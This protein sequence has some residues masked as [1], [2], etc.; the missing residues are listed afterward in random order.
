MTY[1]A[2]HA[3][4]PGAEPSRLSVQ[5]HAWLARLP[6]PVRV[7][8]VAAQAPDLVNRIAATWDDV[9][10]TASL[11]EALLVES[12]RSLPVG[13]AAELLRLYEYHTRCCASEAPS[14]TW[15]LPAF[16]LPTGGGALA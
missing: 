13:I 3:P 9:A 1:P 4:A 5:A 6:A 7:H 15:E 2:S 16:G 10:G 11:L 14:T 8:A 12:V